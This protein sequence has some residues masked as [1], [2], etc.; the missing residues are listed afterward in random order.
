MPSFISDD[1]DGR[2]AT[3]RPTGA[4][5]TKQPAYLCAVLRRHVVTAI[6]ANIDLLRLE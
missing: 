2:R 3:L 5:A 4:A 1:R 6:T